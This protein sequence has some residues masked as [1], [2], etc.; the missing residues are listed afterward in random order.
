GL[1]GVAGNLGKATNAA[2]NLVLGGGTLQYTGATASTDRA[3]TLTAATTSTFDVTTNNL[4]ISGA[5]AATTGSLAKIGAGTLTFSGTTANA[6]TGTTTVIAGE[7]DL[8]KTAG[9]NAI[10]GALVIG[11]DDGT[12]DHDI[13]KLLAT[14]Q[15]P[16][17]SVTVTSSGKLDLNN[18][19]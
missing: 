19:S 16:S 1:G 3:F 9:I 15:M 14:N 10:G 8:N 17:A 7:L 11:D 4:T 6:Y 5:A 18:F 13:V 2:T 12:A